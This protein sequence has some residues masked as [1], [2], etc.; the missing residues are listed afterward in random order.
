MK[1]FLPKLT[2]IFVMF[3][4][5]IQAQPTVAGYTNYM[6]AGFNVLLEDEAVNTDPNLT[7]EAMDLLEE[8]LEEINNFCIAQEIKDSLRAVV[9]FMDWNTTEGAAVYHAGAQWLIENGYPTEKARCVEISN[10]TN[11]V[12]W[13]NQNQPYMVLHELA[14]AYHHRVLNFNHSGITAAYHHAVT[15]ILY[16]NVEYHYGNQEYTVLDVAYA[17]N[18]E[19]EFFAEATEA[20]FGLNDYYPFDREDLM[21][22][23]PTTFA[24]LEQV[25]NPFDINDAEIFVNG[26]NLTVGLNGASYQWVTCSDEFEPIIG[27]TGQTYAPIISGDYSVLVS[28]GQCSGYATCVYFEVVSIDVEH[29]EQ[30]SQPVIYPNPAKSSFRINGEGRWCVTVFNSLGQSI[31]QG[32]HTPSETISLPHWLTTGVYM[33]QLEQNNE[34]QLQRLVVE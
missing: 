13:T 29:S 5:L 19:F 21:E 33:I 24:V 10:V 11:F 4:V 30:L 32:V 1:S 28:M 8:K 27:A 18:N 16:T 14:H 25:W 22:Y 2:I 31:Y 15:N 9:F 26:S 12:N 3:P 23:D 34:R 6:L 20:Y 7:L 17:L